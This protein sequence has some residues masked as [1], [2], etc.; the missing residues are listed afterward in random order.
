MTPD[1]PTDELEELFPESKIVTIAGEAITI[2][3]PTVVQMGKISKL[4]KRLVDD[5]ATERTVELLLLSH[6]AEVASVVAIATGKSEDFVGG[7]RADDGLQLA[8]AVWEVYAPFFVRR[9][10]PMF[11]E[12][13]AKVSLSAGLTSSSA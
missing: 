7:L 3:P 6:T 9:M 4:L 8:I 2:A 13:A 12:L 5:A 11:A 10:L 1:Q